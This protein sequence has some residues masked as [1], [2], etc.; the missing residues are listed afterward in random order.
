MFYRFEIEKS[1]FISNYR[2]I[3]NSLK[4]YKKDNLIKYI[5]IIVPG[6]LIEEIKDFIENDYQINNEIIIYSSYNTPVDKGFGVYYTKDLLDK[7][8]NDEKL[9]DIYVQEV[10]GFVARDL[11]LNKIIKI[12]SDFNF[13]L[14]DRTLGNIKNGFFSNYQLNDNIYIGLFGKCKKCLNCLCD[15]EKT[16]QNI[17][18][19]IDHDECRFKKELHDRIPKEVKEVTY[20]QYNHI[21]ELLTEV[22]KQSSFDHSLLIAQ[23]EEI[24]KSEVK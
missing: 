8:I 7:N 2:F 15:H 4:Q 14:N 12:D 20:E 3:T 9:I 6:L 11:E 22:M 19:L 17:K 5:H 16:M 18:F 21:I 13:V 1:F 24:N 23:I 10:K